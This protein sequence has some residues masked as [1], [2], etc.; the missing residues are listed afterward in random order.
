MSF[1]DPCTRA[2]TP[3]IYTVAHKPSYE[4]LDLEAKQALDAAWQAVWG[5]TTSVVRERE[6]HGDATLT[7]N[8]I[9]IVS[10][11]DDR[12]AAALSAAAT[13]ARQAWSTS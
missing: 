7:A 9:E 3:F 2:V 8:G 10:L 11:T 13:T 6:A 4:R 1:D 5:D 12:V